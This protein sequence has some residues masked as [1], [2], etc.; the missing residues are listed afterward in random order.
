MRAPETAS[1]PAPADQT[2]PL[3]KLEPCLAEGSDSGVGVE[4]VEVMFRFRYS[5]R[6]R[7]AE[8]PQAQRLRRD[9]AACARAIGGGGAK[10]V[11]STGRDVRSGS[12][13]RT[14]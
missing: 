4:L 6:A 5:G 10:A 2:N 8:R 7:V 14:G 13:E 12:L 11:G 1:E 9:G 3:A